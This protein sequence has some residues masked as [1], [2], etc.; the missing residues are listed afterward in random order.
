M[1][2]H[3]LESFLGSEHG[4]GAA[5]T[6]QQQ[7]VPQGQIPQLLSEAFASYSG[8]TPQATSGLGGFVTRFIQDHVAGQAQG[9]Q[10]RGT[11]AEGQAKLNA[12]QN[13]KGQMQGS[14]PQG[15]A[16]LDANREGKGMN[17][18]FG[19]PGAGGY[20][21]KPEANEYAKENYGKGFPPKG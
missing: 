2:G 8:A 15:Q 12:N 11:T 17:E 5:Q 16:K 18:P 4:R 1:F 21:S 13:A 19:N 20:P 10:L 14:T 6:L 3:L 7:G 9:S